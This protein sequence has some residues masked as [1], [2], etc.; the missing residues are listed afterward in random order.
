[1]GAMPPMGG[2]AHVSELGDGR[3]Q[4]HF[5]LAMGGSW[6]VELRAQPKGGPMVEAEGSL[7]VG[8]EG[9]RLAGMGDSPAAPAAEPTGEHPG[10]FRVAPERLQRIGVRTALVTRRMLQPSLRA[11]G[12]VTWDE[13]TLQDVSLKVRGWIGELRV[14]AVG[15]QVE[16]GECSSLWPGA[17][18]R[19]AQYL[20][21]IQAQARARAAGAPRR[22][23]YR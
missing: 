19:P 17:V 5:E 9:L 20:L 7:T 22:A 11:A 14:A 21:A 2:P 4:A 8:T 6:Q 13:T 3:Y 10:E 1:M 18:C 15:A 12:R 16:R 23:D